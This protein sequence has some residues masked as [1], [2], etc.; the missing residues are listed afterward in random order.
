M[1]SDVYSL[2]RFRRALL[3]LVG[4]RAVQAAARVVLVLA[5]VRVLPVEEFAAYMLIV[6]AAELLLQVGS[7]GMLPL[8]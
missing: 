1:A 7:F 4:G 2:G 8:A 6:G 5:L 3:Q